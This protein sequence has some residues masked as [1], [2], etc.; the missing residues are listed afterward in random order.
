VNQPASIAPEASRADR[1][2]DAIIQAA[3]EVFLSNGY[4]GAT[5]DEVAT[6][7][8]VSKQTLY[9]QF[10]DKQG[11]FAEVILNSTIQVGE[12]L[13][14]AA[15]DALRD[16]KDVRKALRE[17]ADVFL[18]GML[19]PEV[20]RLRR[21]VI[22][23]ADRFPDVGRAWYERGFERTLAAVGAAMQGLADRGLLHD[24][25]DPTLAAYQFAGLVMYQPMN[26]LMFAGT[27]TRPSPARLRKIADAAV[28]MFLATYG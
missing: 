15:A 27:D 28:D 7:A 23:E 22:A 1:R 19:K 16:A 14:I 6:R 18:R 3:V 20:V 12:G 5:T 4:L 9:K 11:L 25:A 26:Q 24:L 17:V 13:A 8:S 2:R 21:L 10:A